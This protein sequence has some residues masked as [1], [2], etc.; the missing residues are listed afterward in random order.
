LK[1]KP[2]L[3]VLL[4]VS[5]AAL[6]VSVASVLVVGRHQVPFDDAFYF[7]Y[8]AQLLVD[9]KGWFVDPFRLLFA[10][11]TVPSAAHPPLWTL[12][13][14]F[15]DVLGIRSYLSHLLVACFVD[16]AAVFMTGL[17]A[18][19]AAGRRVGLAA[20]AI[21]T[22]YPNY[23]L[24][25]GTGL[26]ETMLLLLV[27]SVIWAAIRLQRAPSLHA[28]ALL[29]ALCALTALTRSE[30]ILLVVVLFLPVVLLRP[31]VAVVRRLG[32]AGV[33]LAAT[34]AVLTPWVGFNLARMAQPEPLSSELGTTLAGA[35]CT[36]TYGGPLLGSW[37][38]VCAVHTVE[39]RV[40]ESQQ[41]A[42]SRAIALHFAGS[43]AAELPSVLAARVGRAFGVFRPFGY[44][45]LDAVNGRPLTAARVGLVAF[46][47][48]AITA[49]LG[50]V[51]L[52]R[53][54]PTLVPFVGIV[55]ETIAVALVSYGS[56]RLRAPLEVVVVVLAGAV[57]GAAWERRLEAYP[58]KSELVS[59]R[60]R[61]L[62]RLG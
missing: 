10:G 3:V 62:A 18:R 24:T 45:S 30:Q 61:G 20:A 46:W 6:A 28:A 27:A 5:A 35:N 47:V 39:P 38:F 50:L 53:R 44:V 1:R 23:W 2:F 54:H 33:G 16:A 25:V 52:H 41:D 36:Q 19:E 4:L 14:A 17:A 43:H 26:S 40:D 51:T 59:P 55:V 31:G 7:H 58:A 48:L 29:G 57:I 9:G 8:Q 60:G 49:A 22:V 32:F 37:S 12:L 34:A 56:T 11:T 21:A 42:H 13:L 15:A